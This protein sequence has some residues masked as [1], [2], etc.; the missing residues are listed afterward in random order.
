[1]VEHTTVPQHTENDRIQQSA[2][3]GGEL[4][5]LRMAL[6]ERFRIV[7]SLTPSVKGCMSRAADIVLS[8]HE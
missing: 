2:I 1:M 5:A 8:W 4:I 6:D 3:R 7:M